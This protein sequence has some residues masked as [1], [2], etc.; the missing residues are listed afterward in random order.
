MRPIQLRRMA[1]IL[2]LLIG[3]ATVG[4]V[5]GAAAKAPAAAAARPSTAKDIAAATKKKT[6]PPPAPPVPA[7]ASLTRSDG[8]FT[9][10]YPA[11]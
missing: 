5:A 8:M 1:W 2:G 11:R 7:P 10:D 3:L 9:R 4:W 6:K